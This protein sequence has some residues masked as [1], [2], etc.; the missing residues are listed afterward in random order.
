LSRFALTGLLLAG[1]SLIVGPLH[2]Q[3]PEFSVRAGPPADGGS[4]VMLTEGLLRDRALVRA[5]ESGL[6]LRFH[7][8]LELWERGVLDRLRGSEERRLVLI[9]DPIDRDFRLDAGGSERRLSTLARAERELQNEMRAT[10]RPG[11]SGR[12]YYLATLEIETLSLSDLEELRRWLRGEVRPAVEGRA[13]PGRAVERGLR[14][15]FVRVIGLPTR[16]YEA[17]SGSFVIP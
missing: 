16:R 6:P 9:Q 13:P 17:R 7:L 15:V 12:Y 2:G 3:A 1:L 11:A 8:R 14:R 5:L 10:L 4:A